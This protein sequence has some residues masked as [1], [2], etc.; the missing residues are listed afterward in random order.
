MKTLMTSLAALAFA[1]TAA[2]AP[3]DDLKLNQI[4]VVGTHNSYSQPADPRVFAV[5]KPLIQP[6]LDGMMKMMPP[7]M[8]ARFA[9][10][11]PNPL[12]AD[13]QAGLEYVHPPVEMQLRAGLRSLEFDLNVDHE[14]G[15]FSDPLAYR[16]L[17]EK[18]AKNLAPLY[19]EALK[20][21]GLKTLHAADID[22]RSS[23]PTF[24][25]CLQQM[26][27]WS[28]ANPGHSPVFVLL[29]PKFN[30]LAG[31]APGA[32]QLI[33][34]DAKAFAEMDASIGEIIGRDRVVAPDDLRGQHATL[35][36]AALAGAWPTLGQARGK[37]VFLMIVPGMNLAAF[38]PYLDGHPNLEGRLAFVQG[39]PGM[40]HA[41][42][43]MVD[44]ALTRGGEIKALV[45]AGR[46][47]RSRSDIDTYEARQNDPAR[48]DAAL[49]S[50]AQV[51]STDYPWAP[52][53]F[54][55]AYAVSPFDG[56]FRC[57]PVSGACA[58]TPAR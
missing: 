19:S 31:F 10:E 39:E 38:K 20:E 44:N 8:A 34:F 21:P 4:Q 36:K 13:L 47:V 53:I 6:T 57:N 7:A 29:E 42:F 9:D 37:F 46:L 33:P 45:K 1:S 27:A 3:G 40:A 11:H 26:R 54:G 58:K 49:A 28:D 2:A 41:A 43:V 52:N 18:G 24:R 14:G 32:T 23:C 12:G 48:R 22:F 50:G 56:G 30:S 51:V 35:E 55:N 17:R 16:L 5:M 25:L 15:R